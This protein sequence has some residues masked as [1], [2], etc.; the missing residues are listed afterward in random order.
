MKIKE[1][2]SKYKYYVVLITF[3]LIGIIIIQSLLNTYYSNSKKRFKKELQISHNSTVLHIK[4]GINV[5]LT[6]VSS[7]RSYIQNRNCL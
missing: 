1:L 4:T 3:L 5:Y 7:I 2:Y 6:V